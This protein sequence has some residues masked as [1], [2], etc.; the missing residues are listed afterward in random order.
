MLVKVLKRIAIYDLLIILFFHPGELKKIL[1]SRNKL[2]ILK[3]FRGFEA[4]QHFFMKRGDPARE[5]SLYFVRYFESISS[6]V[7]KD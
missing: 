6:F 4:L 7:A 5:F 2:K 3:V 1:G